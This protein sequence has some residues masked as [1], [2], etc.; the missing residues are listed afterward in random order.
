MSILRMSKSCFIVRYG[1]GISLAMGIACLLL[2]STS[3]CQ[4]RYAKHMT[5]VRS[6]LFAGDTTTALQK[7]EDRERKASAR[8]GD[9][10]ELDAAII[11]LCNGNTKEAE[12]RLLAVRDHFD[13]LENAQLKKGTGNLLSLWMDDN[14]RPYQG[15]DYEKILV[16]SFLAL[17]N[18]LQ[19]GND[20]QAYAYQIAQ[21]QDEIIRGGLALDPEKKDNPKLAYKQVALGPYIQGI[22]W[23]STWL[24]QK[25][26]VAAYQKTVQWAPWF[27]H[28]RL[29]LG[30][31][32][33]GVHSVK[34]NGVVYIFT[35]VGRGPYKE[36]DEA[37]ATT[38]SLLVADRI[39]S[40][41]SKYSVP[42]TLAPVPIPVIHCEWGNIGAV[43][44]IVDGKPVCATETVLDVNAMAKE[45]FEAIRDQII[46]RAII[47]RVVKKGTLYA[48]KDIIDAN[49]WV[50][51]AMDASGVLWEA[52]ETADTR[53]WALL[54]AQIQ[55]ARLE[56]PAGKHE[57][58]LQACYDDLSPFGQPHSVTIDVPLHRN[59]Y[60]LANF[61]GSEPIGKI[62]VSQ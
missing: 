19:Q 47:R 25:D 42:P 27:R 57:L 8:E 34:E 30:R 5:E 36:Q 9:V 17:T 11:D 26:A 60:V 48:V 35:L 39:F 53:C 43:G 41:V 20:A 7:I 62:V 58:Q 6:D 28:G 45:Q 29:A 56:L 22:L 13:E 2:I 10:L 37:E 54:P 38:V 23:E 61:P 16:R 18:L 15:E 32:E 14:T 3:G 59:T 52:T 24:N 31:A 40:A 44:V 4:S 46:A 49:E 55:V 1:M 33:K 50:S 21:K 51:L 12:K